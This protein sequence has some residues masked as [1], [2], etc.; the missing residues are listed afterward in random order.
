MKVAG[1][2]AEYNPFHSGHLYQMQQVRAQTGADYI[3]IAMSGDFVQR[4]EPAVYDKYTRTAMALNCGA[5][6]VLE[7]PVRFAT[8]SAEDFA[9][10]G[11]KLLDSLGV[12]D[13][14]C[15][16]SELGELS[17]LK[18][19]AEVLCLEPEAY[20]SVLKE[21][22]KQGYSYPAARSAA[23]C[24]FLENSD[25]QSILSASNN[26]L[27]IEYLKALIQQKSRIE[28]FTIRRSG[29]GYNDAGLPAGSG[30]FASAT[31]LRRIIRESA[32]RDIL[33]P[34]LPDIFHG[35]IPAAALQALYTEQA[36]T[37][38]IFPDDLSMLLQYR[39]LELIRQ[40]ADLSSYADMSPEL[41]ARLV[42]LA[43]DF[44]TFSGRIEQLK[45][46]QYTYTRISRALLHLV[47]GI[48]AEP[49][50]APHAPYARILG[51][52]KSS[53][54]LLSAV[55]KS[56]TIPIITKTADAAGFLSP[57][58]C[59]MLKEDMFASH[60]YQSMVF[61]KGRQMKNEYTKSVV[62]LP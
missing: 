11:V 47:L 19:A 14:L 36:H 34:S 6:L 18:A 5:D 56:A 49:V 28:P 31:A 40:N 26:I 39:L 25:Y 51:F 62:I 38:P 29:K 4:G 15:F 13:V 23:L 55:K 60:L 24:R 22:L 30:E 21:Q 41:A 61:Q 17:P 16:G 42:R 20:R 33:D 57:A 53:S 54:M 37:A 44:D 27:A 3:V 46:R 45:T 12:A 2:I 9:A 32:G 8:G 7:L 50:R 43:L 48:T 59:G 35:Q 10:C 1:I 58:A 52:R